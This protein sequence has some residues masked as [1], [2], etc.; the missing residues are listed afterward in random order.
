MVQGDT[1]GLMAR[2]LNSVLRGNPLLILSALVLIALR[3]FGQID[4]CKKRLFRKKEENLAKWVASKK[5]DLEQELL[6]EQLIIS[7][8]FQETIC[9]S[10]SPLINNLDAQIVLLESY[11]NLLSDIRRAWVEIDSDCLMKLQEALRQANRA[12]EPAFPKN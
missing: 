10:F 7:D 2:G 3:K 6:Q 9:R 1:L 8:H 5:Q 11:G 12:E 4:Q